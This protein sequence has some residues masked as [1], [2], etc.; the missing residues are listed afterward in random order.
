MSQKLLGGWSLALLVNLQRRTTMTMVLWM[1]L[2]P[3]VLD[4]DCVCCAC[5]DVTQSVPV[6]ENPNTVAVRKN[7]MRCFGG[8]WAAAEEEHGDFVTQNPNSVVAVTLAGADEYETFV[9]QNLNFVVAVTLVAADENGDFVTQNPN[10]VVAVTLAD[11]MMRSGFVGITS[12]R[13]AWR[14]GVENSLV[15]CMIGVVVASRVDSMHAYYD[16]PRDPL[17]PSPPA[18]V[19]VRTGTFAASVSA[20]APQRHGLQCTDAAPVLLAL[21]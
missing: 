2:I 3:A 10:S 21:L 13:F 17:V 4:D 11:D 5:A 14:A 20:C 16:T 8:T 19:G 6:T 9:T 15:A 12:G 1:M 18:H 7:T